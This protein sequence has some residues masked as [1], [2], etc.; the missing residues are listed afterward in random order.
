MTCM[1][2]PSLRVLVVCAYYLPRSNAPTVRLKHFVSEL[3]SQHEVRVLTADAGGPGQLGEEVARWPSLAQ[4]NSDGFVARATRDGLFGLVAAY[5]VLRQRPEVLVVSSPLFATSVLATAAA[6]LLRIPVVLDVRDPYPEVLAAAGTIRQTSRVFGVLRSIADWMYC[7]SA[8]VVTVTRGF[9]EI[10]RGGGHLPGPVQIIPNGFPEELMQ[11]RATKHK[12]FT[13]AFHGTIGALQDA[14]LL[15]DVARSLEPEGID[16]VVVGRGSS[17][18]VLESAPPNLRYLGQL[19]LVATIAEV[20]R[21]HV[22]LSIRHSD[23]VSDAAIPVKIYEYLGLG[24]PVIVSPVSAGGDFVERLGVGTQHDA[25][26][27]EAELSRAV[28]DL[29]D[30]PT[31]YSEMAMT[32]ETV[33]DAYTRESSAA[34]FCQIVE[35]AGRAVGNNDAAMKLEGSSLRGRK[36]WM[37]NQI[38]GRAGRSRPWQL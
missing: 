3:A 22:G 13:V 11:H 15:V 29:R 9:E 31:R 33:R 6:R 14:D 19:P 27:G 17:D 21:C 26:G 24:M 28:I 35:S 1:S 32:A 25:S 36:R 30:D 16:M 7:S 20:A 18:G 10:I 38:L 23:Q 4:S 37:Q 5:E 34:E 8:T 2:S 12:R